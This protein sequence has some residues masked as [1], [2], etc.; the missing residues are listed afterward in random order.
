VNFDN[1]RIQCNQ[2]KKLE[3]H[4]KPKTGVV[5]S[6]QNV[7]FAGHLPYFGLSCF[8]SFVNSYFYRLF[9]KKVGKLG[10]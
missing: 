2:N 6:P 4:T 1:V 9:F 3:K 10:C 8:Y 7:N 5:Q